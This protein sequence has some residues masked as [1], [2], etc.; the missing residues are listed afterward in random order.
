MT[1]LTSLAANFTSSI[2]V[3]GTWSTWDQEPPWFVLFQSPPN[4]VAANTICVLIG[5][6]AKLTVRP[7][8]S[9]PAVREL[10]LMS[11]TAEGALKAA[12]GRGCTACWAT[13]APTASEQAA[14]A[15]QMRASV[16]RAPPIVAVLHEAIRLTPS[17]L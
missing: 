7:P 14:T 15:A 1:R 17:L 12:A 16:D 11:V 5:F 6:T 9:V 10:G 2:A 4:S 13:R 8:K 3:S